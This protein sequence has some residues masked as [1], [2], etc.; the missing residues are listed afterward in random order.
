[1]D[2]GVGT[3]SRAAS[4]IMSRTHSVGNFYSNAVTMPQINHA[5]NLA[6][7]DYFPDKNANS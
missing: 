4:D 7:V 2:G 1:M 5:S 6:A 3:L